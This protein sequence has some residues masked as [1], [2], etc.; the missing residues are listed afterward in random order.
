MGVKPGEPGST[1]GESATDVEPPVAPKTS[2]AE[3]SETGETEVVNEDE[4]TADT[5]SEEA[6][7]E[8]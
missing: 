4:D 3:A 5:A 1:L 6:P 8:P 2:T 7:R